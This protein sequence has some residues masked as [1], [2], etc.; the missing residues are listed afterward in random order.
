MVDAIEE[1]LQFDENAAVDKSD[2]AAVPIHFRPGEGKEKKFKLV[3]PNIEPPLGFYVVRGVS[4]ET[5]ELEAVEGPGEREE[6]KPEEIDDVIEQKDVDET[7]VEEAQAEATAINED[8]DSDTASAEMVPDEE[9]VQDE[10]DEV[11]Y[12]HEM[13]NGDSIAGF[14][15]AR[16]DDT[17]PPVIV[18]RPEYGEP[19]VDAIKRVSKSHP[20]HKTASLDE[21]T[22]K[23]GHS[24]LTT[25]DN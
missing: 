20:D 25:S 11:D 23:L 13:E 1:T 15:V 7:E 10:R 19:A 24:P 6:T 4:A 8:L 2:F 9:T 18:V 14:L 5:I 3:I 22:A 16:T 17:Q 12:P 21:A